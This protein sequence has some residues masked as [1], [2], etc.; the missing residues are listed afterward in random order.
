[1]LLTKKWQ[2]SLGLI[3]LLTACNSQTNQP[4]P[5]LAAYRLYA[6]DD[7]SELN[8]YVKEQATQL[9]EEYGSI[10]GDYYYDDLGVPAGEDDASNDSGGSDPQGEGGTGDGGGESKDDDPSF[11]GTNVQE[12]GVDEP[13]IVKTDGQRILALAQGSLHYVDVSQ[14]SP[15]LRS[16]L[17]LQ[18]GYG[19]EMLLRGD[20]LLLIDQEYNYYGGWEGDGGEPVPIPDGG[21]EGGEGDSTTPEEPPKVDP[22]KPDLSKWFDGNQS[23]TRISLIDISNPDAMQ[24]RSRLYLRGQYVSARSIDSIAR[25]VLRSTPQGL[26]W[27]YPY[28]FMDSLWQTYFGHLEYPPEAEFWT[29]QEWAQW[30]Q[31]WNQAQQKWDQDY[32]KN[33][34]LALDDAKSHNLAVVQA[35]TE[36]NWLPNYVFEDFKTGEATYTSGLLVNCEQAMRAGVYSGIHTLSVLTFDLDQEL[37]LGN[38]VGIFSQGEIVYSSL[39]NLYVAT[40][41]WTGFSDSE[42]PDD[43]TYI[44]KFDLQDQ[45]KALY[46]ASGEVRGY[47]LNQWAMSEYDRHLRVASTDREDFS[48]ENQESY[49]SVL[50]QDG[51]TLNQVGQV[52]NL[53]KGER[54]YAVRFMGNIGYVV[55]F[56]QVDPLYTIDL[57]NPE[58]PEVVGELKILGYSAYLHPMGEGLLLGVGRDATEE[59]QVGGVQMSLFDVSNLSEPKRLYAESLGQWG[60]SQVE[61]DHRAFL[62]WHN[63]QLAVLP[64]QFENYDEQSNEWSWFSGAA[65]FHVDGNSGID[66]MGLIS[67]P[68]GFED[69]E[70]YYGAWLQRSLVIDEQLYTLSDQGIKVSSIANEFPDLFW[71]KF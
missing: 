54:I 42:S 35:S 63:K 3:V 1:M 30:Q 43:K 40:H 67:H 15:T 13:D 45:S 61:F 71:I 22:N 55:T 33:W 18:A 16:S 20:H 31:L 69:D 9:I 5:E 50:R 39:E 19:A 48:G 7:C 27:K 32:E 37:S 14:D 47:L 62:Y 65:G 68:S 26:D 41:P 46:T 17:A 58:Q 24:V 6:F 12:A 52:G 59:G 34:Q 29:E 49:V 66:L 11:S 38:A 23:V 4:E 10:Y 36:E 53:G 57:S 44:H 64:I 60:N 21:A 70:Y 25:V 51:D 28:E 56:R 2:I 8:T